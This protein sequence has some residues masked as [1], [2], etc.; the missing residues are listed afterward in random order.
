V[1]H[2]P[3]SV[4]RILYVG[5]GEDPIEQALAKGEGS[6]RELTSCGMKA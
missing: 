5:A 3:R 4:R 6:R 1:L 2:E